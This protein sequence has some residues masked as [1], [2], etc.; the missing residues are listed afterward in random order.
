MRSNLVSI[1]TFSALNPQ[2]KTIK[3]FQ[4][5][6]QHESR[7]DKNVQYCRLPDLKWFRCELDPGG[8]KHLD[9]WSYWFSQELRWS[10]GKC[11]E[12]TISLLQGRGICI[13]NSQRKRLMNKHNR[14]EAGCTYVD[15]R[16]GYNLRWA[17]PTEIF[18]WSVFWNFIVVLLSQLSATLCF[19][20]LQSTIHNI[21]SLSPAR[22]P[23]AQPGSLEQPQWQPGLTEA[24]AV[25][26]AA[27]GW[28]RSRYIQQSVVFVVTQ[29]EWPLTASDLLP[30]SDWPPSHSVKS[31][32]SD[33]S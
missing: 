10:P 16:I 5:Y 9:N 29:W 24:E 33:N 31:K 30:H 4:S 21:Q 8:P 14:L 28:A 25:L 18:F 26:L 7:F 3:W 27:A 15:L 20:P 22:R 13:H 32:G 2:W 23:R 11:W 17:E 19:F 6:I 1:T 12:S